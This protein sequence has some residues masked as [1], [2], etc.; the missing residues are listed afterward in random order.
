M[1]I[2]QPINSFNLISQKLFLSNLLIFSTIIICGAIYWLFFISGD[3]YITNLYLSSSWEQVVQDYS[4]WQLVTPSFIHFTEWHLISNLLLWWYLGRIIGSV[5]PAWLLVL[6]V[7][8]AIIS[9]CFQWLWSD[10]LFGGMS[11]VVA[12]LF[13]F[14]AGYQILRPQGIFFIQWYF[15][16]IYLLFLIVVA[17]G[18]FGV[19]SNAAHF[20]GLLWGGIVSVLFIKLNSSKIGVSA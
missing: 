5:S 10:M 14:L 1:T 13:G 7:S 11:G 15:I 12:A 2:L 6:F 20:S 3:Q 4:Y 9:N 19:Y 18:H 17:T 16:G 8:S